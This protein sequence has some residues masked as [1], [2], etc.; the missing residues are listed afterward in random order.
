MAVGKITWQSFLEL[1]ASRCE[2]EGAPKRFFMK[3]FKDCDPAVSDGEPVMPQID[4]PS[5]E[6][7]K[8]NL[9]RVHKQIKRHA[10][11]EFPDDKKI[12]PT[13]N[14]LK[15][16]YDNPTLICWEPLIL[17]N[18][19]EKLDVFL[20]N[21]NYQQQRQKVESAILGSEISK[22][23]L[24]QVEGYFAKRWLVKRLA[25][26]VPNHDQ[27]N[28]FSLSAQP[29]WNKL[30]EEKGL[31]FFWESIY[32]Y[33]K[34]AS[35]EPMGIIQE[36]CDRCVDK[37]LIMA[38]HGIQELESVT[39]QKIISI[40][41]EPL[42]NTIASQAWSSNHGDCVLFLTT[43]LNKHSSIEAINPSYGV[44]LEPWNS[45]TWEEMYQFLKCNELKQM[46]H[47][48]SNEITY[49]LPN[50]RQ[51]YDALESGLRSPQKVLE[52]ICK[53]VDLNGCEDL[54]TYWK[55]AL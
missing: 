31:T 26:E 30:E 39:L 54:E 53:A 28:G 51:K 14:W 34:T 48:C 7:H 4:D 36:L 21:F 5:Y 38:I 52:K 37:P 9:T 45:V 24:V 25:L 55:I 35:P 1:V 49:L 33:A 2:I 16:E 8:K 17:D 19:A 23:I 40:F 18:H 3:T 11:V 6:S 10:K 32:R 44:D 20:R 47:N 43:D 29:K 15:Q 42:I 13:L 46:I 22:V 12:K 27:S 50:E 41:W